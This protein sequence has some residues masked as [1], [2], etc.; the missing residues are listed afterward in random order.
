MRISSSSCAI[1]CCKSRV[2][3][4]IFAS[5]SLTYASWACTNAEFCSS[6]FAISSSF[7]TFKFSVFSNSFASLRLYSLSLCSSRVRRVSS[8]LRVFSSV[9]ALS[10][11]NVSRNLVRLAISL[12]RS[13]LRCVSRRLTSSRFRWSDTRRSY[14]C[15]ARSSRIL[16]R[17]SAMLFSFSSR[18][19]RDMSTSSGASASLVSFT[20]LFLSNRE[21]GLLK[22]KAPESDSIIISNANIVPSEA[23]ANTLFSVS[24]AHMDVISRL[25]A[26]RY[27][28]NSPVNGVVYTRNAPQDVPHT[29]SRDECR[30]HA[31][32][33]VVAFRRETILLCS[34][35][36]PLWSKVVPAVPSP[37]PLQ[38]SADM[39]E[40]ISNSRHE[41]APNFSP[42]SSLIVRSLPTKNTPF[43][44]SF[45]RSATSSYRHPFLA[46]S[47]FLLCS[48]DK[49]STP[50]NSQR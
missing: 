41:P 24:D 35:S 4:S 13:F 36:L 43:P 47:A 25:L 45:G 26:H 8:S 21:R 44:S 42:S 22:L 16:E 46:C 12:S 1:L 19:R 34:S 15:L 7:T 37:P 33:R 3:F 38:E 17:R 49:A 9:F 40:E 20:L 50:C 11:R 18:T 31:D 14:S 23:H 32:V 10:S 5:D 28:R 27:S 6:H 30:K 29:R 48:P 39:D 2:S